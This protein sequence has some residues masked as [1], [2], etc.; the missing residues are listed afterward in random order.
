M[1]TIKQV[2]D[3]NSLSSHVAQNTSIKIKS[4]EAFKIYL[5]IIYLYLRI[6][7]CI[8]FIHSNL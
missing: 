6:T 4:T 5:Y 2:I 1:P 3:D 8:V 7:F